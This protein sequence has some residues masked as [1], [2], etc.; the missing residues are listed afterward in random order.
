MRTVVFVSLVCAAE[1]YA[2]TAAHCTPRHAAYAAAAAAN[3]PRATPPPVANL[4]RAA[5]MKRADLPSDEEMRALE[6]LGAG[7]GALLGRTLLGGPALVGAALGAAAGRV[8]A[9]EPGRR[10]ALA[11]ELGFQ[12]TSVYEVQSQR[13]ANGWRALIT[14]ARA[15]GLPDPASARAVAVA[16][17]EQLR[18]EMTAADKAL[19]LRERLEALVKRARAWWSGRRFSNELYER[20]RAS[21]L[22]ALW[23]RLL[24]RLEPA[25]ARLQAELA[26]FNQRVEERMRQHG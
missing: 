23:A 8:A 1:A 19:R 17:L 4:D 21:P 20:Y 10:G 12:L 22:P 7:V 5:S 26:L 24:A 13:F 6:L 14:E 25:R 9:H 18:V 16:A 11:R 15:R 3:T 2:R